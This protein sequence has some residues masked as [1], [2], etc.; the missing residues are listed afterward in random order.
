M[1]SLCI[2]PYFLWTL[3]YTI[4]SIFNDLLLFHGFLLPCNLCAFY[5]SFFGHCLILFLQYFKTCYSFSFI[6]PCTPCEFYHSFVRHYFILFVQYSTTCYSS[7][8]LYYLELFV[9]ST[10]VSLDI[11]LYYLCNVLRLATLSWFY[12]TLHSLCI[13]P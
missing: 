7:V 1:H 2:L 3:S 12:T 5:H 10:I 4:C 8:V 11:V 6:L 9:H 13:L